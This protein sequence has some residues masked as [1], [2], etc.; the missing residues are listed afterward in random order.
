MIIFNK[1]KT[2]KKQRGKYLYLFV[3]FLMLGLYSYGQAT[4][5]IEVNWP[6]WS[7]E[8]LVTFRSPTNT[9]IGT[10]CN[11][12]TCYNGLSNNYYNNSGNPATYTGIAYGTGYS[13]LLQDRYGDG[14]NG[15]GSYVRVYQD[16]ILIAS[17]DLTTGASSTVTF[18]ILPP[19]LVVNNITVNEDAG[20]AIFTV[21]HT[22]INASGSYTVDY[23]ISGGTATEGVDYTTPSGLYTGTLS[24][25]GVNGDTEQITVNITDDS[26]YENSENFTIQFTSSSNASVDITDTATGTIADNDYYIITNGV[27]NTICGGAFFDSG[28]VS[29]NYSNKENSTYTLCPSTSD[30]NL[31]I[32]FSSFDVEAGYDYLYIYDGASTSSTLVGQ[33]HNG[34]LP[35]STITATNATGCLTFRFTSDNFTVGSGWEASI[36]CV[37][38][39][40]TINIDDVTVNEDAGTATFTVTHNGIDTTGSFMVNYTTVDGTG[41]AGTDYTD[42]SGTLNFSGTVGDTKQITVPILNNALY[43]GNKNFTIQ[44]IS[45]TDGSVDFS[46]SA[47]GTITDDE[48]VLL[49]VPLSLYDDFHGNYDYVMTGGT[50]RT[51]SNTTNACSITTTSSGNLTTSLS[52][53]G[54]TVAKAYLYWAHSNPTVDQTVTLEGIEVTS[55]L[56]YGAIIGE[57]QFYGYIADVTDVVSALSN[58]W[59]TTYD[60]SGLTVD[61]SV[62]YCNGSIVL[63]AWSLMIFYEDLSLPASTINL[64]YGFDSTSNS[65]TSFTLDN[66]YAISPVGS[67]ATFLSYEGDLTL[68]G[69]SG[70]NK[71]ELS[72]LPQGGGSPFILSGDGGQTGNNPFNSTIYDETS[73]VNISGVYGLDLDTYN[74]SSYISSFDTEVTA[75]VDMGQDLV[76][77]SAVVLRVPSNLIS[78]TV[79]EDINYP[80]GIGRNQI[81]SSGIG[82]EG[83]TVQLFDNLGV[84]YD[85]ETTDTNGN[86][87]FGGM[88]DGTYTL[89]VINSTVNSTRGGGATCTTCYGI[90]TF[91]TEYNGTTLNEVLDEVGG[92]FPN[93]EDVGLGTLSG[94]QSTSTVVIS[95]G[96]TG[97]IDF[98]FNF[99]T[100]VNTNEDGQGSLEQFIVNSN[101]LDEIGLDIDANGIFD[102]ASGEDT[103]IFMIPSSSDPLGRTVDSNFSSGYFNIVISNGNPL[104]NIVSP[105][106]HIDGRTQTA[107][108]GNTNTGTVGSGGVTVGVSGNVLPNYDLPEIQLYRAGGD[109]VKVDADDTTIR[110]ISIYANNNSGI[111]I[112]SGNA[113]VFNNLLGVNALGTGSGNID[114][115]VEI[116]GGS[117]LIDGN[118]IS[119]NTDSGV[120]INGGISTIV[121]NNHIIDNGSGAC[122]DNITVLNG[123]GIVIQ[124]NLIEN[125]ASIGIDGDDISGGLMITENTIRSSGQNGGSCSGNI[126]NAGILLD[127]NNSSITNNIITNNGGSGIVLAGGNTFG[128]LIS[129]NSIYA[130]GTLSPALGIDIDK[131][132]T[133]GD[134]VTINDTADVDSGPNGV[135]NFPIIDKVYASGSNF[136]IEGWSRS[137]ATI[138][139]FLTDINQGTAIIGDNQLGMFTDYGEG[140]VYIASFVEGDLEDEDS[141]TSTYL[142]ND[143]NTDNTNRFKFTIAIPIGVTYGKS[144][145]STATISNSTS[146]FSPISIIK[147]YNVITNRRITYRVKEQ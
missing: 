79:F 42:T 60:F 83:A 39:G 47:V 13:L 41:I 46:D 23:L 118:Y 73:G 49:D 81:T 139:V 95:A 51:E 135:I 35:P 75:N 71:E 55:N 67:K 127:G 113:N 138:E 87:N 10:I 11:P 111:R 8:N 133:V 72:I 6:N 54:K 123:L 38:K 82:I 136:T 145:T 77:S 64:Y 28:G 147:K 12:A 99:N 80:G 85:T 96:G 100:I 17:S 143:N 1:N 4:I 65:G 29:S 9:V 24:F 140:Q 106:T 105:N 44:F 117:V 84:L 26:F 108:S 27:T 33:Y 104:S 57:A 93:A 94:A 142:D 2:T 114:S 128:N 134:G 7:S 52:P 62:T 89:R 110:N 90:Q 32:N 116:I 5:T 34:N 102:P 68:D 129:R 18:N 76:I 53:V 16:G 119:N 31:S 61:N 92:A 37:A 22:N 19:T 107:Y 97:N 78:G 122:N 21:N 121:Q 15:A 20:T 120:L 3:C 115:G 59:S 45:I 146:E 86:Y 50:L 14:W 40:A 63:G 58:P 144:I 91:R 48:V 125:A 137:G 88:P 109:V 66:F 43:D 141:R 101:N 131:S 69:N 130:N 124:Q 70:T 132:D 25:N 103:S 112:N 30:S 36:S 56:V 74:I 126:E 98:G